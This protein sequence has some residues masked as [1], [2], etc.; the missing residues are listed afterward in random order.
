MSFTLNYLSQRDPRWIDDGLGFDNSVSIG[1]DGSAL[2]ALTMLVNGY[3]YSETPSGMNHKFKEMGSGIGF[4]GSLIVWPG[5]TRAFPGIIFRRIMVCRDQPAPLDEINTSLDSGQPLMVEINRSPCAGLQHH[6]VILYA[7]QKED[8]LILDPWPEPPDNAP[9]TLMDRYGQGDP[10]SEFITAVCWFEL[11]DTPPAPPAPASEIGLSMDQLAE[12]A[13]APNPIPLPVMTPASEQ[14]AQTTPAPVPTPAPEPTLETV[15]EPIPSPAVTPTPPPST[16]PAP[17]HAV[18]PG[19]EPALLPTPATAPAAPALPKP[20]VVFVSQSVGSVGLRLRDQPSTN[21]RTLAVH[22]AGAQL[23]SLEPAEQTLPKI[24]QVEQWLNVRDENG[25]AGYVAAGYVESGN[26]TM[27]ESTGLK[28]HVSSQAN[29]GL[30]LRDMPSEHG[31]VLEELKPGTLLT[32]L[33][34][35][36]LAQAKI[37]AVNQ[38]LKVK[39]PG[40]MTGYVAAWY[41]TT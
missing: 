19:L 14:P 28:V 22:P 18:P 38:W 32:V 15:A 39:Q 30:R 37:G 41:V 20:L 2:V 12:S 24:G 23:T 31:N 4:L 6:W 40:G 35:A 1:T 11:A 16:V 29:A 8:Y 13:P 25:N 27:P 17:T 9:T 3:G 21:C 26:S 7:R 5:V 33:E 10:A 36:I 34:P